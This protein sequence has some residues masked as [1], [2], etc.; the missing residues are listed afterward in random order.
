MNPEQAL[1]MKRVPVLMT[2]QMKMAGLASCK[3]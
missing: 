1:C 2:A 3:S